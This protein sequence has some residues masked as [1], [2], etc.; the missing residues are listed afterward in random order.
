MKSIINLLSLL[1]LGPC[2]AQ[3][4][5]DPYPLE[6]STNKMTTI[7]FPFA[8]KTVDRG[9]RDVLARK[10]GAILELKAAKENIIP[11]NLT[12]TTIDGSFYS[13]LI[14]Y[15]A[16]PSRLN[17]SFVQDSLESPVQFLHLFSINGEMKLLLRSIYVRKGLLWF[18]LK[19]TNYSMIDFDP[20]AVRFFI[21]ERRKMKRRAIQQADLTPIHIPNYVQVAAQSSKELDYAF[22]PFSFDKSKR[23][24]IEFSEKDGGRS[25]SLKVSRHIL[26]KAR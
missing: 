6:I 14:S 16:G 26:L 3:R 17:I 10:D 22:A 5:I 9:S 20:E 1:S 12:V 11:T 8:V 19:L 24:I 21:T 7:I 13:F 4:S 18:S 15:A 23:L 2:F 25:L